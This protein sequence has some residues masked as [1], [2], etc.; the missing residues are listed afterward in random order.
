M[1]ASAH[2]NFRGMR[3]RT[4]FD[5]YS[6]HLGVFSPPLHAL[7]RAAF[8]ALFP[9]GSVT[10]L[11][12]TQTLGS[13]QCFLSSPCAAGSFAFEAD[14]ISR[15]NILGSCT[16]GAVEENTGKRAQKRRQRV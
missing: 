1:L 9:R 4:A 10:H 5:V 2:G 15:D 12:F 8:V 7:C 11:P 14:S 16:I 6:L 3:I 13:K